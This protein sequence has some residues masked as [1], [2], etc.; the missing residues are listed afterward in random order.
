MY[1]FM[2]HLDDKVLEYKIKMDH[3]SKQ[4][5][6]SQRQNQRQKQK[7]DWIETLWNTPVTDCRKRIIWLILPQYATEIRNM[8][9]V[10]A[11]NWIKDWANRCNMTK[12]LDFN[13]DST[14]DYYLKAAMKKDH[15]PL[16]FQKLESLHWKMDGLGNIELH[17]LLIRKRN[18]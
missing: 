5:D 11:F 16:G 4:N 3:Q 9:Y 1:E 13:T 8:G 14:I 6:S 12:Q 18:E 10:E 15:G 2:G 7:I 17:H